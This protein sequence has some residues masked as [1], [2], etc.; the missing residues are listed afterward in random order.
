MVPSQEPDFIPALPGD[1]KRGG[2]F[3][4]RLP[5]APSSRIAGPVPPWAP[6]R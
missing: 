5:P 3:W 6:T 1:L 4:E 2:G